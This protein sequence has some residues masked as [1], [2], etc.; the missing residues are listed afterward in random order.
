MTLYECR[1]DHPGNVAGGWDAVEAPS[2]YTAALAHARD[3]R[4]E[5]GADEREDGLVVEVRG[6]GGVWRMRVREV[7]TWSVSVEAV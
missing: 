5:Y 1:V 4:S 2:P 7:T 6:D 3:V